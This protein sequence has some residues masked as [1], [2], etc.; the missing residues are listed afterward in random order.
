MKTGWADTENTEVQRNRSADYAVARRARLSAAFPGLRVVIPAGTFRV[1]VNDSDYRFRAS[2]PYSWL[3]GIGASEA[4]PDTVLVLEPTLDGHDA[5]LYLHPRSPRDTDEFFRDRRHG[6]FWVGRRV[7]AKE[8]EARNGIAVRHIDDLPELLKDGTPMVALRNEDPAVDGLLAPA[9]DR[10]L[11]LLQWLAEARL[12]KDEYEVE[13]LQ[14]AVDATI[15]GFEDVVRALPAAK[16]EPNGERVVEA[17]FYARARL[18]GNE[19]GYDTIAA[20]GAHA[21]VLHWIR[22]D[23][24][25]KDGDLMLLDAGV[26]VDSHYTSDVTRTLPVSG[27]FTPAQRRMY[28]LV[29]EAQQA[30]IAAVKPGARFRDFHRAAMRVIAEGLADWGVLPI[31]GEESML[32]DVGLH[33]RWTL[34]STGHMLGL[35]VHDCAKARAEE[36]LDGVLQVGNVLTIE[37]GLY[38][39]PDDL[40]LPEE[41]RGIGIR[42]EDDVIVTEDG[43]RLLTEALPRHPDDIERWMRQIV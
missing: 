6:E 37:P 4:V 27:S 2:S 1:R 22:N 17:A 43:C 8:S 42:I 14:F 11:E 41:M 13:E 23:G 20:S 29:Y 38:F 34:C 19:P 25:V 5:H 16:K 12:I 28:M 33:R 36:Y 7:T 31:S 40:L 15:R 39:Q 9:S 32:D 10:E 18:E 26:E 30:A 21:C 35:D 3:T 24:A